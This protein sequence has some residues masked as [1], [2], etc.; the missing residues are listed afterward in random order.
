[1]ALDAAS[2]SRNCRDIE[3]AAIRGAEN[4]VNAYT[5]TTNPITTFNTSTQSCLENLSRYKSLFSG[6]PGLPGLPDLQS[7]LQGMS[8]M[9]MR[10]ACNAAEQ[11][12]RRAVQDSLGAVNGTV[13]GAARDATGGIYTPPSVTIQNGQATVTGGTSAESTARST[14]N[15]AINRVIN[16]FN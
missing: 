6:Y 5:P 12:F 15:N 8:D 1:M 9:F 11:Q 2:A 3:Q 14:V 10:Q 7:A 4:Y 16:V 13:R